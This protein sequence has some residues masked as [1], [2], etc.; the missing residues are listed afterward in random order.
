MT[1]TRLFFALAFAALCALHSPAAAQDAKPRPR[2]SVAVL[3]FGETQMGLRAADEL[4]DALKAEL[5][6]ASFRMMPRG[7]ARAAAKGAGYTGSLNLSL[8]EARRPG[9]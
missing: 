2:A 3:D 5:E 4:W 7:A 1:K 9:A 6:D 8:E